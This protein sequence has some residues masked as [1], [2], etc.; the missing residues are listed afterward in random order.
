MKSLRYDSLISSVLRFSSS[1]YYTVGLQWRSQ[2]SRDGGGGAKFF[3]R[4]PHLLLM[5]EQE[6][7][8]IACAFQQK[9]II[10]LCP[11]ITSVD[12]LGVTV[13]VTGASYSIVGEGQRCIYI[14]KAYLFSG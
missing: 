4:N 3:D 9:Y 8:I 7:I 2:K 1:S 13:E 6:L 14:N 11:T 12:E 5:L 10:L